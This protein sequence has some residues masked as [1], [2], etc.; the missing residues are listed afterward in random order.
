MF[1]AVVTIGAPAI[2]VI[3]PGMFLLPLPVRDMFGLF[4]AD[5]VILRDP[6]DLDRDAAALYRHPRAVVDPGAVPP[7]TPRRPPEPCVKKEIHTGIGDKIDSGSGDQDDLGGFRHDHRR[8]ADVEV[9]VDFR[10]RGTRQAGK[11]KDS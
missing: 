8:G 1:L 10:R 7:V 5:S 11:K 6:D 4:I 9:D 2:I 3:F